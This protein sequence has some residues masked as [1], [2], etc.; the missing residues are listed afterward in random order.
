[1]PR[2]PVWRTPP[3]AAHFHSYTHR[4][5]R[6]RILLGYVRHIVCYMCVYGCQNYIIY[7]ANLHKKCLIYHKTL[8]ADISKGIF[9]WISTALSVQLFYYL[10]Q[11]NLVHLYWGRSMNSVIY[12]SVLFN[13]WLSLQK[14]ATRVVYSS[15]SRTFRRTFY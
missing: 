3:P 4:P 6:K 14:M 7:L 9:W 2:A 8:S 10:Y 15:Y 12:R 1:M 5:H 11:N 13:F